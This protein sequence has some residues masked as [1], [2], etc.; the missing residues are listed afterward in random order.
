M[1]QP[2]REMPNLVKRRAIAICQT[3]GTETGN[4]NHQA[5]DQWSG[6][7]F[8]DSVLQQP[9]PARGTLPKGSLRGS[10]HDILP[11]AQFRCRSLRPY[12]SMK[13][14]RVTQTWSQSKS[15]PNAEMVPSSPEHR[16]KSFVAQRRRQHDPR[17]V[18]SDSKRRRRCA[19][20]L[21]IR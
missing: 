15:S 11:M 17:T 10:S 19:V 12:P 6:L 14:Y 2:G 1:N 3:R 4:T 20:Q 18:A 21:A 9:H 13:S 7:P 5:G 8:H 16:P